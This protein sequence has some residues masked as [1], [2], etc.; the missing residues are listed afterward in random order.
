[1]T[2]QSSAT[3]NCAG[4]VTATCTPPSGTV[5]PVGRD[6]RD[7]LG[8][9]SVRQPRDSAPSRSRSCRPR[10]ARSRVASSP[11]AR[12]RPRRCAGRKRNFTSGRGAVPTASPPPTRCITVS[13]AGT[14][15]L[16]VTNLATGCAT[17]ARGT[18]SSTRPR[19]ARSAAPRR[20]RRAA[21]RPCAAR[22]GTTPGTGAPEPTISASPRTSTAA[23]TRLLVVTDTTTHC[24]SSA[25]DRSRPSSVRARSVIR[26]TAT[27]RAR[28]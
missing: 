10:Y 9:G 1:M 28:P 5:F 6:H 24:T 18:W 22:A 4:T 15:S 11:S 8:G 26:T 21:R 19:S 13:V 27:C 3:D 16:T 20:F 25:R 7:L 14:Y 17:S 12:A 2:W 23:R